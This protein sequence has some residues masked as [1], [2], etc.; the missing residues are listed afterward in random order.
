MSIFRRRQSKTVAAMAIRLR[1]AIATPCLLNRLVLTTGGYHHFQPSIA[2]SSLRSPFY[3]NE[4][5]FNYITKY[6]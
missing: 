2:N 6:L 3:L 1:I 5:I 4:I